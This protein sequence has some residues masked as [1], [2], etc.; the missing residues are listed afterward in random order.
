MI[1]RGGFKAVG[2]RSG[3][4]KSP[5]YSGRR[6]RGKKPRRE[7]CDNDQKIKNGGEKGVNEGIQDSN[8]SNEEKG[9]GVKVREQGKWVPRLRGADRGANVVMDA[10]P[11]GKQAFLNRKRGVWTLGNFW[12]RYCLLQ[13]LCGGDASY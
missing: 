6:L 8:I 3:K 1:L 11:W 7:E 4:N 9:V 12:P 10:P 2:E 5:V 13:G